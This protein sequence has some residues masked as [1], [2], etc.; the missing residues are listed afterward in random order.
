MGKTLT[1]QFK[2]IKKAVIT[3]NWF[4]WKLNATGVQ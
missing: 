4:K 2:Y 1:E 3:E